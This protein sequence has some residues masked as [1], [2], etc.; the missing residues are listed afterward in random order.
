M[1]IKEHWCDYCEFSVREGSFCGFCALLCTKNNKEFIQR[2]D[3]PCGLYVFNKEKYLKIHP[4][5]VKEND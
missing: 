1:N 4:K 5:G 3:Q 2:P